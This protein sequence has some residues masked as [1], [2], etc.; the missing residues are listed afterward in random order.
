MRFKIGSVISQ[1]H[2][3]SHSTEKDKLDLE[4]GLTQDTRPL[5]TPDNI[6]FPII[7]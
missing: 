5:G 7:S 4:S 6:L 3:V 2:S 1:E